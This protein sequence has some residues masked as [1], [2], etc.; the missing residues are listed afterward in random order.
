MPWPWAQIMS[1]N[2]RTVFIVITLR[3]SDAQACVSSF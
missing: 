1:S 2:G 3:F